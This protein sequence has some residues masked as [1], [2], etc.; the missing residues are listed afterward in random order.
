MHLHGNGCGSQFENFCRFLLFFPCV[1]GLI[2]A[3]FGRHTHAYSIP[4]HVPPQPQPIL[5]EEGLGIVNILLLIHGKFTTNKA[6]NTWEHLLANFTEKGPR[7]AGVA[8]WK[9]NEFQV[10][11]ADKHPGSSPF[12][13][14]SVWLMTLGLPRNCWLLR[15]VLSPCRK[16][17]LSSAKL[18]P[19]I[20]LLDT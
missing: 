19:A 13:L 11:I 8:T 5:H 20:S 17:V 1:C 3:L 15:Y 7:V 18:I 9:V 6:D 16:G 2:R 14:C 10:A 12:G 4:V